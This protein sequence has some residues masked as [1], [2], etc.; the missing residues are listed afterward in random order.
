MSFVRAHVHD[1]PTAGGDVLLNIM[2]F[3]IATFRGVGKQK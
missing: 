3:A 2:F 1:D